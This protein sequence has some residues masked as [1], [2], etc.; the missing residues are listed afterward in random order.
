MHQSKVE[1]YLCSLWFV[2]IAA[3]TKNRL[4]TKM[5]DV[6]LNGG[7]MMPRIGFGTYP[8]CIKDVDMIRLCMPYVLRAGIKGVYMI[9]L[10]M[11][12]VLRGSI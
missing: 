6:A 3:V 11:P 9:S 4:T 12:Y 5:S 1:L 2:I 8:V 10:C 7:V